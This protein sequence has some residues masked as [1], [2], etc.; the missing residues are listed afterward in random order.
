[1]QK[2]FVHV[3]LILGTVLLIGT[4]GAYY[5][6]QKGN[7][8]S[9]ANNLQTYSPSSSTLVDETMEWST[10]Q[11]T[12]VGFS[13]KYPSK[14][15]K[16]ITVEGAYGGQ[17]KNVDGTEDDKVI[18]FPGNDPDFQN[19]FILDVYPYEGNLDAA[20]SDKEKNYSYSG[21]DLPLRLDKQFIVNG[22]RTLWF[23]RNRDNEKT[24]YNYAVYLVGNK[25]AF[26][27]HTTPATDEKTLE[28]ILSTFKFLDPSDETAN[29]KT[30]KNETFGFEIKLPGDWQVKEN[31]EG[32]GPVL[33]P[34]KDDPKA[35][36]WLSLC[37]GSSSTEEFYKSWQNSGSQILKQESMNINGQQQ[38]I[39]EE[40]ASDGKIT[41]HILIM[42][43]KKSLSLSITTWDYPNHE[44]EVKTFYPIISTFKFLE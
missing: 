25:H 39:L 44:E 4:A 28:K 26:A 33:F 23:R 38:P 35:V 19:A 37:A 21:G 2:G 16:P 1:M 5:F 27:L 15:K 10:Y 18:E 22:N 14:D 12:K 20:P 30:Y 29:W 9:E 7:Q 36:R 41:T 8:K 32:C 42:N 43:N 6:Y 3:V 34:P 40:K 13:I 24:K 11:N 17:P 31:T